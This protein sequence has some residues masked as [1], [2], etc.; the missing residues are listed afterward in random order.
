MLLIS[1]N[2]HLYTDNRKYKLY[3]NVVR[4]NE[5]DQRH[6]RPFVLQFFLY[7]YLYRFQ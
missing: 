3:K 5:I 2:Y 7:I 1:N 4:P 6:E